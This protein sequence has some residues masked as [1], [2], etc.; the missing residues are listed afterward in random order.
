[1]QITVNA[2]VN[3]P[4]IAHAGADVVITL[5]VNA[6]SLAGGGTDEDG[7]IVSYQWTKISG[8]STYSITNSS[9]P[10][11]DVTGLIAGVY[12]FELLVTDNNGATFSNACLC[13]SFI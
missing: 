2:A 6:A 13:C 10:V 8:P 7:A 3:I 5:P 1:M 11:T 9:S 4:P 12:K